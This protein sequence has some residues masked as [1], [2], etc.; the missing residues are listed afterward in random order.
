MPQTH[1]ILKHNKDT[2]F[3]IQL[4]TKMYSS[5]KDNIIHFSNAHIYTPKCIVQI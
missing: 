3:Q 1:T 4:Y 5:D 2:G